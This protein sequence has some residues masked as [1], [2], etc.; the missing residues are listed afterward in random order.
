MQKKVVLTG[1]RDRR[2]NNTDTLADR[3]DAN[4]IEKVTDFHGLLKEKIY[5]RRKSIRF[6]CIIRFSKLYT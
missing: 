4:L 1:N 6:F 5:H 2:L 3:T